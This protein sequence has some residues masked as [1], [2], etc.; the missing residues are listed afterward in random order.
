M[1]SLVRNC[2]LKAVATPPASRPAMWK[3]AAVPIVSKYPATQ[4]VVGDVTRCSIGPFGLGFHAVAFPV[5]VSTA[6]R[7]RRAAPPM[8][9]NRPPT[10]RSDPRNAM[11]S[12]TPLKPLGAGFQAVGVPSERR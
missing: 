3:R 2:G 9:V 12:T 11:V 8:L 5:A 1:Y 7:L 4:T 6:A 10:I